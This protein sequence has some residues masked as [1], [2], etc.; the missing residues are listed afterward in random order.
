MKRHAADQQMSESEPQPRSRFNA[1]RHI[2]HAGRWVS[3]N[4]HKVAVILLA[5]LL[6]YLIFVLLSAIR[7]HD[8]SG[9]LW[10]LFG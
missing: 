2:L 10:P 9:G 1:G 5:C 6:C 8:Y 3:G 7:L 4:P